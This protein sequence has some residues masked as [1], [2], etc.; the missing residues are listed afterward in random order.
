MPRSVGRTLGLAGKSKGSGRPPGQ[1]T[2]PLF[3]EVGRD[4]TPLFLN[5]TNTSGWLWTL[6]SENQGRTPT[7][8]LTGVALACVEKPFVPS[9]GKERGMEKG[10]GI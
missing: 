4:K 3:Y 8:S 6:E 7:T 1:G 2:D 5:K 9:P 10:K